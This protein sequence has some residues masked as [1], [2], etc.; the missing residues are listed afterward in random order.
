MTQQGEAKFKS[1]RPNRGPHAVTLP[2]T[3]DS[4]LTCFPPGV[5]RI[6]SIGL[7]LPFEIVQIPGRVIMIFEYDHFVRE[8]F[9]DGRPHPADLNLTWMG[10]SIGTWD[11][12]TLVVDTIGFNDKTWLDQL[13]H[14]HSDALHVIERLRRVSP[15]SMTDDITMDDPKTYRKPWVARIVFDFRPDWKIEE[16]VCEDFLNTTGLQKL[17]EKNK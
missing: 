11:G 14:P 5:P 4:V 15:D 8:I 7:G 17:A 10:D 1:A 9:T 13:G 6:Y 2:H 16:H 12:E 3:N